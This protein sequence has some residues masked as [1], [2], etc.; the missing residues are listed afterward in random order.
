[1]LTGLNL[2]MAVILFCATLCR[3]HYP[4]LKEYLATRSKE[5]TDR[6]AEIREKRIEA[7]L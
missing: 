1:V 6:N 7:G 3:P 2:A 5:L 4:A